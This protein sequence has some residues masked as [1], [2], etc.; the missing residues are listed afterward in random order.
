MIPSLLTPSLAPRNSEPSFSLCSVIPLRKRSN[1]FRRIQIQGQLFL[2]TV[3]KLGFACELMSREECAPSQ[4]SHAIPASSQNAQE[5]SR[6]AKSPNIVRKA[7]YSFYSIYL[8]SDALPA[9]GDPSTPPRPRRSR[10]SCAEV[11]DIRISEDTAKLGTCA[12]LDFRDP[13][14]V[15]GNQIQ[16]YQPGTNQQQALEASTPSIEVQQG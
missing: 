12:L 5:I 14:P 11:S 7:S 10:Q 1:S 16:Q 9:T 8:H 6:P 15:S 13:C 4:A 3:A 2:E